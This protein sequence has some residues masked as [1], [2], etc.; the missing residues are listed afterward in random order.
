MKRGI[1][2]LV[3][4]LMLFTVASCDMQQ[5][6]NDAAKKTGDAVSSTATQVSGAVGQGTFKAKIIG[7]RASLSAVD[8]ALKLNDATAS[9]NAINIW[10]EQGWMK[11]ED[12]VKA[13]SADAYKNI[14]AA[15]G[16]VKD[17][18]K[19]N[20]LPAAQTATDKLRKALDDFT[21]TL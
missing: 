6:M 4:L 14:E 21:N 11:I 2:G 13:K 18:I 1:A 10:D 17:N 5:T 12:E 15:L 7:L 16:E 19:A 3:A 8:A 9:L 20:N